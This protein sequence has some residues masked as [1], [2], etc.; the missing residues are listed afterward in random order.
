[1]QRF[2][3]TFF[4]VILGLGQGEAYAQQNSAPP[5]A[6]T[7]AIAEQNERPGQKSNE[8]TDKT[9]NQTNDRSPPLVIDS[10]MSRKEVSVLSR[11][12][13]IAQ[14][15]NFWSK[16][17]TIFGFGTLVLAG[18]ATVFACGAWCAGKEGVKVTRKATKAEYQPY[19]VSLDDSFNVHHY[20][21]D[22]SNTVI[23]FGGAFDIK[24]VGR[25]P[26]SNT[27]VA[28][29]IKYKVSHYGE[30]RDFDEKGIIT[31][32]MYDDLHPDERR[33]FQLNFELAF[34]DGDAESFINKIKEM[35]IFITVSFN[36]IF[37]TNRVYVLHFLINHMTTGAELQGV[38]EI[39]QA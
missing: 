2:V 32:W 12:D 24:N 29:T 28:A 14:K 21:P 6:P 16:W 33:T 26:A 9:K 5:D 13:K 27:Q 20:I 34:P 19:I 39:K 37:T 23:N 7:P 31:N 15:A 3:F 11:S 35:D 36:D 1:M 38:K 10:K 30:R 17:Q 8:E 18:F 25:T 4:F 22:N